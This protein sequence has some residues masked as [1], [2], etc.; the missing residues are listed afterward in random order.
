[1]TCVRTDIH[2]VEQNEEIS[3]NKDHSLPW[4]PQAKDEKLRTGAVLGSD[5]REPHSGQTGPWEV[6]LAEL[7]K[8]GKRVFESNQ[9]GFLFSFPATQLGLFRLSPEWIR[10]CAFS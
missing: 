2:M 9:L 7:P 4:H 1:M 8:S 10:S 5:N 6:S 3:I